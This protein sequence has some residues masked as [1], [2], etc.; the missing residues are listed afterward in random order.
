MLLYGAIDSPLAQ[1]RNAFFGQ[2]LSAVVGVS[3]TKLFQLSK[4]F[5]RM[6]WLAG[7]LACG[8]SSMAMGMTKTVHPPAGA[9]ALLAAVDASVRGIGWGLV[10]VVTV[11]SG[12]MIV[13]ACILGNLQRTYPKYWWTPGPVGR[14][15]RGRGQNEATSLD[16]EKANP[17]AE[18]VIR[19]DAIIV[20][21]FLVLGQ[22]EREVLAGLKKKIVEHSLPSPLDSSSCES[23]EAVSIPREGEKLDI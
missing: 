1:P 4:D 3:V 13:V 19:G 6:V 22:M 11:S 8:C 21:K 12:V 23:F 2:V 14:E 16:L 10:L 18:V 5:D 15:A 7:A 17:R 9:T 20:P